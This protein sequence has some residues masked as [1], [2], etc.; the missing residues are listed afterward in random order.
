M[1]IVLLALPAF[2]FLFLKTCSTNHYDLPYFNPE[3]GPGNRVLLNG[4][5]TVYY[6]VSGVIGVDPKGDTVLSEVLD[7]YVNVFFTG[8]GDPGT[9]ERLEEE[10]ERL[11]GRLGDAGHV[12]YLEKGTDMTARGRIRLENAPDWETLLK[13]GKSNGESRTFSPEASLVLVDGR[14]HIRGYYDLLDADD[15]DRAI[16][17]IKILLYQE[18]IS[19]R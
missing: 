3:Y 11:I 7:G 4:S 6:K 13:M 8:S 12:Q 17:E 10:K 2:F 15:F 5:D 18:K 16:A 14:R 1:L 19:G 9:K